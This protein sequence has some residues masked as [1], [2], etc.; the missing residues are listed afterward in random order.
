MISKGT[1]Q[2]A[3]LYADRSSITE[4]IV[5]FKTHISQLRDTVISNDGLGRKMDF[6]LQE[7]NREINTIGSKSF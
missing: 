5:R 4:E 3:A 2:E 7:M 6:L 1:S